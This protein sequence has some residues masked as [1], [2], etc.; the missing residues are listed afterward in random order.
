MG[1]R[2]AAFLSYSHSA[3]R[4]LAAIMQ[5]ALQ[6]L[7]KPWYRRAALKIFRDETSLSANPGLWTT[8]ERNLDQS[9]YLLLLGSPDAAQSPWVPRKSN[10]GGTTAVP[11]VC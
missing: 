6:R 9:D 7:A 1:S 3:D 10:R 5:R 2:Y 8:I 11:I 4:Q